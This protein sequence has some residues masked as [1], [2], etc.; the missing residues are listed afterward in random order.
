[1]KIRKTFIKLGAA[2]LILVAAVLVV[3]AVLNIAEGRALAGT[4]TELKAKGVPLTAAELAAPCA[5]ADNAA[6]LWK[7]A[8]EIVTVGEQKDAA[9]VARAWAGFMDHRSIDQAERPA[10][11]DLV[12]RNQRTFELL[13][14]M[15]DK[16]CFLYRDP[17]SRLL[18]AKAPNA[19]KMIRTARLLL[20][21]AVLEAEKG[22]MG[23]AVDRIETG[24]KIATL[25]AQEGSLMACLIGFA[26]ARMLA[27][28]LGDMLRARTLEE[29]DL[30]RLMTALE[31]G[32]WPGRLDAA[33]RGESVAFVEM[34]WATAEGR[35]KDL[36]I[37]WGKTSF[38]ERAW[39]WLIRPL[40]KRDVRE[41]L[42]YYQELETR[43]RTP[44]YE[45]RNLFKDWET[46]ALHRPWYALIS[47]VMMPNI[48]ATFL[49]AAQVEAVYAVDQIGLA[50]RLFK[51]RTGHYPEGLSE[52]VPDI[53]K[54]VP[55]DPFTGKPL[56]Y[57]RD[58]EGFIVY[59]LGSNQKDDGGR[60][61]FMITQLVM[62][63]DDDW[64][65]RE[66]R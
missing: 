44:Y 21:S 35:K 34:G 47:K 41:S 46:M 5:D 63:K 61:T 8:E 52:L 30:L 26:D 43:A 51:S 2:L 11:E 24:L 18:E 36:S 31:P 20:F 32:L 13:T 23:R 9:L 45:N 65:W 62:S 4:L 59:S 16:P 15:K 53:L 57:R 6:R 48:E 54:E 37:L 7:A 42:P 3:R 17:G 14:E 25:T 40:L 58:G 10:L 27:Y 60:S 29:R 49:K 50:C 55:I 28:Y 22:Q 33:I 38:F 39:F 12:A 66:E 56:V 64:T 1:M 19:V